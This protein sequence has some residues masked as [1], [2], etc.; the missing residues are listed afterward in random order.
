MTT[1]KLTFKQFYEQ[2][3]AQLVE[4]AN[5]VP[6]SHTTY[7]I[8]RY[9]KL[10]IL[11]ENEKEFISLKPKQRLV[12][13]WEYRDQTNPTPL[14]VSIS[15]LTDNSQEPTWNGTKLSSWL[16]KNTFEESPLKK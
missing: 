13:E 11:V 1:E 2:S 6:V 15:E 3:K 16:S 5:N 8:K 12:V 10:P 7:V 4:A 9:C 14:S